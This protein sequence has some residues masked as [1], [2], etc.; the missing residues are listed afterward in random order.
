VVY[1]RTDAH[2]SLNLTVL[3]VDTVSNFDASIWH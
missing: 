3:R 1:E 2:R